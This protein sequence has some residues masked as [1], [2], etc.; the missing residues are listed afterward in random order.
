[1]FTAP[2]RTKSYQPCRKRQFVPATPLAFVPAMSVG[3]NYTTPVPSYPII[4]SPFDGNQLYTPG[5][6]YLNAISNDGNHPLAFMT[7]NNT[8]RY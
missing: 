3:Q 5:P 7:F 2:Y 4:K 6:S 8:Q 1:M